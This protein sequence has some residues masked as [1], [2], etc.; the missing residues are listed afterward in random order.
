MRFS[1]FA[2]VLTSFLTFNPVQ[3][4]AADHGDAPAVRQQENLDINDVYLFQSPANAS[5]V[6]MVMTVSPVAGITGPLTFDSK[7]AYEFAVDNNG[8]AKPDILLTFK[9]GSPAADGSQK[10][11]LFRKAGKESARKIASGRTGTDVGVKGGIL[12]A[13]NFDDPFFFDLLSFR[14][15]LSFCTSTARNFFNGL[16]T[17]AIVLEVP[18]NTLQNGSS[19]AFGIWARTY[20]TTSRVTGRAVVT[21]TRQFD[22][23]GRPAI[24]TVLVNAANKD[25]FNKD[26][27]ITDRA[28]YESDA[29]AIMQ[30]LGNSASGAQAVGDILFP[31]ILTIDLASSA[32][33]PNGRKLGDDVIDTALQLVTGNSAATDCIGV[34]STFGLVFPYLASK[35]P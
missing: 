15:K 1:I 12:R 2:V 29:V 6:V 21:T 24:N 30:S 5:N 8:D 4:R 7:G 14:N 17:L 31:D 3:V 10:L 35:N 19:T 28:K 9:F 20:E 32:G 26:S 27:P 22:R 34:D 11:S 25:K 16:N 33:F 13:D 23:M 18:A